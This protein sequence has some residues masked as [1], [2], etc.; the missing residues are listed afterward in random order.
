MSKYKEH[1]HTDGNLGAI[2][3][4][5]S[6]ASTHET[7]TDREDKRLLKKSG[8][9]SSKSHKRASMEQAWVMALNGTI[10]SPNC[11]FEAS[12]NTCRIEDYLRMYARTKTQI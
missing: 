6:T 2:F 5:S 1:E 8:T 10:V 9:S 12:I 7:E 4:D 3:T 11:D